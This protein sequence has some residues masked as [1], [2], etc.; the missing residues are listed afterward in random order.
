MRNWIKW[1]ISF[2]HAIVLLVLTAFWLNTDFSYGDEQLLVKWSSILKRV[3]FNIDED[4]PK[5]DYLFI[6]L[7]YEKALIPREEGL[8]NE[9]ITDR[10]KLAQF[11]EILKRNQKSV[12]FTV[13]DVFLKGKS[14]S[15]SL[16]QSSIS[17]I[18]NIVFPTHHGEDG[19][20]EELD[21]NVPHAIADYRMAS[22]GFLKF[23]LFQDDNLSTIPVYLYEKTKGRKIDHQN[24]LYFDNGKLSLNS[25]IIDYQIRSHEL[26][27]Q[28]E[29]PVVNLSELLMLPEDVIVNEFLKNRIVLIGD[30]N[31]DVH[32][33]IFGS[34]PGTLILLNVYL[35]LKAGYHFVT[36]WWVVFM[37]MAYTI[38]SRLMLFPENDS[39]KIKKINWIGP[40]LGSATYLSVL[41][42][43]SYLMFNI[44]LQV[45]ILTLYITLLRY[46]IRLNQV[47]W[48]KDQLKEWALALRETYF[49]FK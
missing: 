16:L 23:K 7:A 36:Y 12:K 24:G 15:D 28:G 20:P 32:E 26:F 14:E 29:Y 46:I 44:H 6:N 43:A 11:F 30:F 27:E 13:C 47:E 39:E 41:S 34:T 38:F 49:N 45:L 33:T 31:N 22:G 19:K 35:T 10:V 18:K 2:G 17:G 5:E 21:L 1:L 9:V 25:T 40:L 37:L 8:G 42:V 3:V 48:S 4:P